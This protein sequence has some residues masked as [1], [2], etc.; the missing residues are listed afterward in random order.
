MSAHS[1]WGYH[2][3]GAA[4]LAQQLMFVFVMQRPSWF[5]ERSWC[6]FLFCSCC[7]ELFMCQERVQG[8]CCPRVRV[9]QLWV[10]VIHSA[11]KANSGKEQEMYDTDLSVPLSTCGSYTYIPAML[12]N[13]SRVTLLIGVFSLVLSHMFCLF[14]PP[15][16][17]YCGI[18]LLWQ[19]ENF[20]AKVS[21][22]VV[23]AWVL[24]KCQHWPFT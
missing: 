7:H 22:W 16:G 12:Y 24:Y 2:R 10:F 13:F 11:L 19:F 6:A 23:D 3:N 21:S 14:P 20:P 18:S 17:T 5:L 9:L 1:W 4:L 15:T 8:R